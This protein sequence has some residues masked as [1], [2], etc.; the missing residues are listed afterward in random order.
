[1]K[2]KAIERDD[3]RNWRAWRLMWAEIAAACARRELAALEATFKATPK[4]LLY[5]ERAAHVDRWVSNLGIA[6][7][8]E[9]MSQ[10]E[11]SAIRSE[12]D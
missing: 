5:C 12:E 4:P 1:M 8:A 3:A 11:L 10:R 9:R 7:H 6:R 2:L